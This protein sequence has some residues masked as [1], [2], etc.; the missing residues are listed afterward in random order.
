MGSTV[1]DY[2]ETGLVILAVAAFVVYFILVNYRSNKRNNAPVETTRATAYLK[3]P[4]MEPVLNGRH[5][6]YIY[7][8]T[9]HTDCGDILKLYMNPTDY[10]SISEGSCGML[11]WQ[12]DRFWKFEK[13]E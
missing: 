4:D 3:H 1:L 6:T 11:T 9:F 8:I 2:L 7:Y 5:S 10:F 13:E 12:G